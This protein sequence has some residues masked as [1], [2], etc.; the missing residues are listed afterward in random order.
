V[1]EHCS[2]KANLIR[3][4]ARKKILANYQTLEFRTTAK[5]PGGGHSVVDFE[6]FYYRRGKETDFFMVV[7]VTNSRSRTSINKMLLNKHDMLTHI[8]KNLEDYIRERDKLI[9]QLENFTKLLILSRRYLYKTLEI[10]RTKSSGLT[11]S[12][13]NRIKFSREKEGYLDKN[14]YE[15]ELIGHFPKRFGKQYCIITVFRHIK[16]K[17]FRVKL[18]F[19]KTLKTFDLKLYFH[20]IA[21]IMDRF[22]NVILP[23]NYPCLEFVSSQAPDLKSM[24]MSISLIDEEQARSIALRDSRKTVVMDDLRTLIPRERALLTYIWHHMVQRMSISKF[25]TMEPL[26]RLAG[27]Q[28][29]LKQNLLQ[30]F[31]VVDGRA[32]YWIEVNVGKTHVDQFYKLLDHNISPQTILDTELMVSSLHLQTDTVTS[33]KVCVRDLLGSDDPLLHKVH[34]HRFRIADLMVLSARIY[35]VVLAGL[36][37]DGTIRFKKKIQEN[38][39]ISSKTVKILKNPLDRLYQSPDVNL[40]S[41]EKLY[42]LESKRMAG[43]YPVTLCSFVLTRSPFKVC[44]CLLLTQDKLLAVL[45]NK[46]T[47]KI[48]YKEFD[49]D[50]VGQSI[51]FLRHL[52]QAGQFAVVAERV[53]L[54]LF[55][56]LVIDCALDC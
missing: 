5:V 12:F 15:M 50:Y 43:T 6:I 4:A 28:A 38:Q 8:D 41:I 11:E 27:F 54:V 20:D 37:K 29:V 14:S 34:N 39:M 2:L 19:Q 48:V 23:T 52:I 24:A 45:Q 21:F 53:R 13:S 10:N 32:S 18:Y 17:M 44:T 25:V 35:E 3:E 22:S 40:I 33:E 1:F 16:Q 9:P 55:N 51:P 7:E 56:T 47:L 49:V 30:R 31:V 46:A 42:L 26:V 36:E